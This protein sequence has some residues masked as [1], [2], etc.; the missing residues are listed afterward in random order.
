MPRT[1]IRPRLRVLRGRDIALGPGKMELLEA[2][3]DTG[4][5]TQAAR[6][7]NMSYMRAWSL[8]RTMNRCFKEPLVAATHGG[9]R[10]G[11]AAL[12]ATGEKVLKLYQRMT[13]DCLRALKPE[14]KEIEE[15]LRE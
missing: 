11:G 4:S 1:E 15:M 8:I 9:S 12:T 10:G 14:W 5:I 2:L 6:R 3:R 13:D 7:L